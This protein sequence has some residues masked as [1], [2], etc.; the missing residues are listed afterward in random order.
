MTTP[1]SGVERPG[2]RPSDRVRLIEQ[3]RVA[4]LFRGTQTDLTLPAT[5]SVAS[6]VDAML[7]VLV[8][9][10]D[11]IRSSDEDGLISAGTVVLSRIDGEPLDRA[12][13]LSQQRITDGDLLILEVTDAQITITP[14]IENAS[15]AIARAN[16][17]QF[18]EVSERTAVGFAAIAAGMASIVATSLVLNAWRINVFSGKRWELWPAIIIAGLAAVLLISGTLVWWRRRERAVANALWLSTLVAGPSAAVA[19]APSHPGAW[20]VVLAAA[21]ATV[22]AVALWKLTPAPPMVLAWVSIVGV[23]AFGCALVHAVGVSLSYVWTAALV[24]AL[25]VLKSAEALAARLAAIPMPPFPTATGKFTFDDAEDI[26]ADALAAAETEGTPSVAQLARAAQAANG[27]LTAIV[28]ATVP[29]FVW[30][31]LGTVD[32]GRG[33]WWLAI[34]FV[35]IIAAVLIFRGRAFADPTPAV[36]VVATGLAMVTAVGIKYALGYQ[37]PW[38]SICIAGAVFGLGMAALIIAAVVPRRVFS[39]VIRK[40]IEWVEYALTVLIVPAAL[41]LLNIFALARNH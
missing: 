2:V 21:T 14:V 24:I 29:F 7:R 8:E 27:Y 6:V 23:G 3:V 30:G 9:P 1:P 22:V 12:Q 38:V 15:S 20:H 5:S 10:G 13:T 37:N 18:S 4:V 36:L 16:A 34:L 41:W 40:M 33:R 11:S 19:A 17:Q 26:A 25:L 35:A 31:A 39:P 28:A 32:P